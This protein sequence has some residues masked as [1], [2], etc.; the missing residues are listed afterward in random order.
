MELNLAAVISTLNKKLETRIDVEGLVIPHYKETL[1]QLITQ[2][3]RLGTVD[4]NGERFLN[5]ALAS[6]N[7]IAHD[8]F[9]RN[10][11]AFGHDEVFEQTKVELEKHQ[12]RIAIGA[13]QLI[14]WY[15][16]LREAFGIKGSELLIE[17]DYTLPNELH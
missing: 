12:K 11:N 5:E 3:R 16:G 7:Y 10:A 1:G 8:F 15:N 14:G 9:N 6:R 17:Q 13:A 2:L 4:D